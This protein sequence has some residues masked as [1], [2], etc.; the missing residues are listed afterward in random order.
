MAKAQILIV[1]DE[2]ILAED[3]RGSLANLGFS[4][5]AVSSSGEAAIEKAEELRPDL[6]LMDIVLRGDMDGIQAAEQIRTR[7]NIPVVYLTAYAD[8]KRLERAKLTQP[9]GYILKPFDDRELHTNIEMALYRHKMERELKQSEEDW[10][11]SFDAL[12]DVML[13]VDKDFNIENIN[14]S[15]LALLGQSREEVIGR[16]CYEIIHGAD[17][18]AEYCLCRRL[19]ESK[20]MESIERY[21]ERFGRH[22]S[23]KGAPIFD[24][25]GEIMKSVHLW[26]DI[27][28]RKRAEEA[29]RES[30]EFSSSLLDNAPNPILVINPDTSV[31]YV[32]P[33][34]QKLTGFS[35]RDVVGTKAP[36]AW[37]TQETLQK[38]SKD[39]EE[40]MRKG[41]GRLEELFQKRDG[42]RF[43]VEITSV[44]VITHGEFK[45][46]LANWLDITER[47]RAEEQLERSFVDLA[48]ALS[49]TME[50]RD[51]YTSGH[52]Q[53]VAELAHLVGKK[54]GLNGDRLNWLYIGGLIHDIGKFSTPEMILTNPGELTNEEWSLIRAHAKQ[55]YDI[56]KGTRLP[57]PVAELALHHHERLDGSGYPHGISGDK[58]ILEVRILGVC[59]VVEAM[60]SHRPYRPARTKEQVLQELQ[61]GRGTKYDVDVVDVVVEIVESG[62]FE[63]G[64]ESLSSA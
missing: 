37:W 17:G 39:L 8:E 3:I 51:P 13:I 54:I 41:A 48:R 55:G 18:P 45:Y 6:V 40:A 28:E 34:L 2:R 44:P 10:R 19:L 46:Y 12:E 26:R 61:T 21:E 11:N 64:A 33:A 53:R 47:K 35:S 5:A 22:F 20:K 56:L 38:T 58:L 4:V 63:L 31:R 36:Y 59:D 49:R 1:E 27:T 23:M 43:W 7:F 25:N 24:E 62:E 15:G 16:K 42:E 60:G 57:W 9:F 14:E 29:L 52:Q 30:E 32:N 50:T